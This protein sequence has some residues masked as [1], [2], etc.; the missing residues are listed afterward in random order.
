MSESST[1]GFR[2]T[3]FS[4][5]WVLD[6]VRTE[7]TSMR[8]C[9]FVYCPLSPCAF[10]SF[11]VNSISSKSEQFCMSKTRMSELRICFL[12][13]LGLD[14]RL[15]TLIVE[16]GRGIDYSSLGLIVPRNLLGV[17]PVWIAMW[18]FLNSSNKL[19]P[20]RLLTPEMK[21]RLDF[22]IDAIWDSVYSNVSCCD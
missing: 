8:V 10:N 16:D 14:L 2:G 21:I 18:S 15:R 11:I 1:L 4:L 3:F 7:V 12:K 22:G 20:S 5:G 6:Q 17:S 13:V 9:D 19:W